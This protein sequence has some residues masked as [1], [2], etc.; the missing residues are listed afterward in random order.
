MTVHVLVPLPMFKELFKNVTVQK[1]CVTGTLKS[2]KNDSKL[3]ACKLHNDKPKNQKSNKPNKVGKSASKRKSSTIEPKKKKIA[4]K[5][6]ENSGDEAS[7][8]QSNASSSI[9]GKQL[10][11]NESESDSASESD[12]SFSDGFE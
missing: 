4:K 7:D 8:S 1:G 11:D 2:K 10:E 6:A 5:I 12:S 3:V 9:T